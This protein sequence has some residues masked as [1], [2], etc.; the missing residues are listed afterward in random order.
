MTA[1]LVPAEVQDDGYAQRG[2]EPVDHSIRA[3]HEGAPLRHIGGFGGQ[4]LELA[5]VEILPAECLNDGYGRQS[6]VDEAQQTRLRFPASLGAQ[7][8]LTAEKEGGCAEQRSQ[9]QGEESDLGIEFPTGEAEQRQGEDIFC[10]AD[11]QSRGQLLH[12]PGIGGQAAERLAD[13]GP[14]VDQERTPLKAV[15]QVGGEV[16]DHLPAGDRPGPI[17]SGVERAVEGEEQDTAQSGGE[18][19]RLDASV[20]MSVCQC[21][22]KPIWSGLMFQAAIDQYFQRPGLERGDRRDGSRQRSY[23]RQCCKLA[24][25]VRKQPSVSGITDDPHHAPGL[26][27]ILNPD[28]GLQPSIAQKP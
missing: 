26:P 24:A 22:A 17:Q 4:I 15:K 20:D 5:P 8:E 25:R 13:A 11:D 18:Y 16:I 28:S 12:A 14:V 6:L 23:R 27:I 9:H 3:V 21:E 2:N 7:L 10:G 19:E 1:T